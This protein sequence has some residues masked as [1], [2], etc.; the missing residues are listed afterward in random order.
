[1]AVD[2]TLWDATAKTKQKM[3]EATASL[4]KMFCFV[5]LVVSSDTWE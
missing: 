5:N 4:C 2:E 3:G 1:M